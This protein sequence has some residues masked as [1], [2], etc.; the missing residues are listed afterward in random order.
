MRMA[1]ERFAATYTSHTR[2]E[3][4]PMPGTSLLEDDLLS[5]KLT[6][7]K[8]CLSR[9]RGTYN[10]VSTWSPKHPRGS[11]YCYW[12]GGST[13]QPAAISAISLLRVYVW[14]MPNTPRLVRWRL[15]VSAFTEHGHL[16][17]LETI[18]RD[19]RVRTTQCMEEEISSKTLSNLCCLMRVLYLTQVK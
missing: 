2:R 8:T 10:Q 7:E 16:R 17:S 15:L 9:S 18:R 1:S 6:T 12:N 4:V 11:K 14:E 19:R 3:S 13:P 5:R